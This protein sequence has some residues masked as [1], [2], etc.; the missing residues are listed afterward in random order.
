MYSLNIEA[1]SFFESMAYMYQNTRCHRRKL[2]FSDMGLLNYW[3]LLSY[4][5]L[6]GV[7]DVHKE[8]GVEVK[9]MKLRTCSCLVT[10]MQDEVT[11]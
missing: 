2:E 11:I 1:A 9:I 8:T 6:M 3:I 4:D 10:T 7:N 5:Y